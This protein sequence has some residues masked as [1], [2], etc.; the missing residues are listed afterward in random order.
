MPATVRISIIESRS[1]R[2]ALATLAKHLEKNA[3]NLAKFSSELVTY[4]RSFGDES[5]E[6]VEQPTIGALRNDYFD[7]VV[8]VEEATA[9]DSSDLR[10]AQAALNTARDAY[11]AARSLAGIPELD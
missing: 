6:A 10:D 3:D 11:N 2:R 9:M 1:E 7:A 8:A 4:E 5:A